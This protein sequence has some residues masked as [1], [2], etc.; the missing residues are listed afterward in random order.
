MRNFIDIQEKK[1][2]LVECTYADDGDSVVVGI[3][4]NSFVKVRGV[5]STANNDTGAATVTVGDGTTTFISAQSIK[6][7]G[8]LTVAAAD[9]FV[10]EDT[11]I[12]IAVTVANANATAGK[13]YIEVEYSNVLESCGSFV[14]GG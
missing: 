13:F 4:A 6:S 9:K 3:P 5:V 1:T 8:S 2:A 10:T 7:A 12:T 14:V 11:N